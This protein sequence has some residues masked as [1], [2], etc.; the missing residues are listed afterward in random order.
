MRHYKLT[1]RLI[2]QGFRY[3]AL[4]VAFWKFAKKHVQVLDRYIHKQDGVFAGDRRVPGSPC[5]T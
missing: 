1:Q 2:R 3:S 4:C 5:L